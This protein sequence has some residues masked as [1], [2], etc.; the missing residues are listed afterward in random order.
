MAMTILDDVL[1]DQPAALWV[2][3]GAGPN[4][5]DRTGRGL[6][7]QGKG[8]LQA[9]QRMFDGGIGAGSSG[10]GWIELPAD[11]DYCG[12]DGAITIE[13]LVQLGPALIFPRRLFD[14][15]DGPDV[16]CLVLFCGQSG[17]LTFYADGGTVVSHQ[18]FTGSRLVYAA[19]RI[20]KEGPATLLINGAS[21][22]FTML[23]RSSARRKFWKILASN[24]PGE[25][26]TDGIVAWCA[27]Y[28]R[29]LPV[30][31]LLARQ[32]RYWSD[33]GISGAAAPGPVVQLGQVLAEPTTAAAP[34][35]LALTPCSGA[36]YL[37][38]TVAV[39]PSQ[40]PAARAVRIY[41]R[42]TGLLVTH[43]RSGTDGR[44]RVDGLDPT[45]QYF[46]VGID[47]P[48]PVWQADAADGLI[49]R[50]AP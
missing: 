9:Q 42:E 41:D 5:P 32:Q 27:L 40:L 11:A 45:R 15:G 14:F 22:S 38:G 48:A 13:L 6:A 8:V 44:Y 4:F 7:A 37:E 23:P 29:A 17:N 12:A 25:T 16:N 21:W 35:P 31:R 39:G 49:P 36:G 3:D 28:P 26:P 1:A 10:A 24:W 43:T 19:V 47:D 18:A 34:L 46:A 30:E 50:C 20:A 33:L 2:F